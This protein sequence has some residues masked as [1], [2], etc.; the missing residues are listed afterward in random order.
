MDLEAANR[1]NDVFEYSKERREAGQFQRIQ[2]LPWH[3]GQHDLATVVALAVALPDQQG[4][5]SGTGHVFQLVQVQDKLEL[6]F[7]ID[8]LDGFRQVGSSV[9]IHLALYHE[10]VTMLVLFRR[11]LHMASVLVGGQKLYHERLWGDELFRKDF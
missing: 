7:G 11:D 5:E 1:G 9:T 3:R 10:Q 8:L 6:T 4:P 2:D